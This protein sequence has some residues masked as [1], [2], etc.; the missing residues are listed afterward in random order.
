MTSRFGNAMKLRDESHYI[1]NMF[2]HMPAYYFIEFVI[3]E[4]IW[5]LAQIVN[6]VGIR[7]RIRVD[8]DR[9]RTL[10]APTTYVE[11]LLSACR[12]WRLGHYRDVWKVKNVAVA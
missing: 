1:G 12:A 4:G 7:A 8:T 2:N 3:R 9:A 5:R 6:D 10:V 11:D